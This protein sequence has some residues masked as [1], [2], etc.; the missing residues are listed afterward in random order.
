MS[1]LVTEPTC[2]ANPYTDIL[3]RITQIA[4]ATDTEKQKRQNQHNWNET[5]SLQ[6][7]YNL[8]SNS[9]LVV[10]FRIVGK[11]Q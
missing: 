4:Y 9:W 3:L 5:I 10:I 7:N 2:N 8:V 1:N 11:L 6:G